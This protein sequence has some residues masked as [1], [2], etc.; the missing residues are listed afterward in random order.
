MS[1]RFAAIISALF[2]PLL[3][4][5]YGVLLIIAANPHLFAAYR[6]K[7]QFLWVI[8][9]FVFTFLC[10]VVWLVM[11]KRLELISDYNFENSKDRIIPF[12]AVASFYMWMFKLFKPSAMETQHSNALISLMMLGAAVSIFIG[13]FINIFRKISIHAIGAGAFIGL[14]MSLM[15]LSEYDLRFFLIFVILSAGL[16]GTARLIL[17]ESKP[18]EVWAGYLTG[19]IGQFFSFFLLHIILGP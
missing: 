13:F 10:P 15:Q 12:I 18:N 4:P 2:H 19:F 6:P 14:T 16:V 9:A 7:D 17:T 3:F 11:M 1:K 5:T 8:I